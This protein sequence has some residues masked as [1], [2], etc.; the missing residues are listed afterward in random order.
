MPHLCVDPLCRLIPGRS[1]KWRIAGMDKTHKPKGKQGNDFC[2]LVTWHNIY[3]MIYMGSKT[4]RILQCSPEAGSSQFIIKLL[5]LVLFFKADPVCGGWEIFISAMLRTILGNLS[6]FSVSLFIKDHLQ[7]VLVVC[8][9]SLFLICR[10]PRIIYP[11]QPR[12][13]YAWPRDTKQQT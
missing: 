8:G 9:S 7:T 11:D 13:K 3:N 2:I 1:W 12:E 4:F 5:C 6:G 10:K